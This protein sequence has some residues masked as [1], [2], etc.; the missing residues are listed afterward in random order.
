LKRVVGPAV[1]LSTLVLAA[2]GHAA[3]AASTPTAHAAG[4]KTISIQVQGKTRTLLLDAPPSSKPLPLVLV[5]HG[6]E[7]TA[8]QTAGETDFSA[9]AHRRHE[10][11]AFMQGVDNT[12][13]EGAGNTPARQAGTDDVA[14]TRAAIRRIEATHRVD[15]SRVAA[16]GFSNG[17][18]MVDLLGCRLAGQ[19]DLIVPVE[20]QLPVSVSPGCRPARPVSVY[21]IHGTADASI[22]YGGGHF[23]GIGGGTTVLSAPAAVR[24]WAALDR[25]RGGSATHTAGSSTTLTYARCAGG[26][27]VALDTIHGGTHAWPG[28]IGELVAGALSPR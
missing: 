13:N 9:V 2:C 20:G 11:V 17:A 26:A 24:R 19:I 1:C 10:I 5:Y 12:W 7:E 15:R 3:P 27:R 22:P 25:C 14:F 6:A 23:D 21:E 4:L 8:A 18:L 16:A 28:G